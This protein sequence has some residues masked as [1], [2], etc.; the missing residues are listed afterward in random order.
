[1][2]KYALKMFVALT[3]LQF[4]ISGFAAEPSNNRASPAT[5]NPVSWGFINFPP[6]NYLDERNRAVGSLVDEVK[7]VMKLADVNYDVRMFPNRRLYQQL[8]SGAVDFTVSITDILTN[9]EDFVISQF[10]VTQ[11]KVN[12][13]WVGDKA[14]ISSIEDLRGKQVILISGYTYGT[15][16]QQ[17]EKQGNGIQIIAN[18][19]KHKQ[20]LEA[21]MAGRGDYLINYSQP[22][23]LLNEANNWTHVKA[24][25]LNKYDMYYILS[26]RYPNAEVVMQKLEQ[27]YA[28]LF[29]SPRDSVMLAI[30]P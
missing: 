16:R 6:Y 14:P 24:S 25:T 19:E 29:V 10:P 9:K 7:Q 12:A 17:L 18:I 1:M 11:V 4:A 15:L 22:I 20:A 30:E 3:L 2:V 23:E 8:N 21:L 26:R 27:A 28:Q 5:A 13:F